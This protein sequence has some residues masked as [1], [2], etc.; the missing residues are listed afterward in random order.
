MPSIQ[1]LR[2]DAFKAQAGRCWYCG[3][4][5]SQA[6]ESGPLRCTAEHL[7][8]QRD[9]GKDT[10]GNIVAACWFCNTR[11]HKRKAP[12]APEA[13]KAYVRMRLRKGKWHGLP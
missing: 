10:S 9:G 7:V 2:E 8:A 4:A 6:D 13:H 11:R 1:K 12:R 5:M 3:S